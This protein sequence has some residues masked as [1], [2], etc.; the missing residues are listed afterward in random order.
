[1]D[2]SLLTAGQMYILNNLF[3]LLAYLVVFAFSSFTIGK[4]IKASQSILDV[5]LTGSI[6]N[7]AIIIIAAIPVGIFSHFLL[8]Y[9]DLTFILQLGLAAYGIYEI[10]IERRQILLRFPSAK[11]LL[12]KRPEIFIVLAAQPYV[13]L[14]T[15]LHPILYEWDYSVYYGTYLES[16]TATGSLPTTNIFHNLSIFETWFP[17]GASIFYSFIS[18]VFSQEF[19]RIIPYFVYLLFVVVAYKGAS[20]ISKKQDLSAWVLALTA[21]SPLVIT[22]LGTYSLYPDL[23]SALFVA[24]AMIYAYEAGYYGND[25]LIVVAALSTALALLTKDTAIF[26]FPMV[27]L[28][29]SYSSKKS[30]LWAISIALI[31]FTIAGYS[32]GD[33]FTGGNSALGYARLLASVPTTGII[34]LVWFFSRTF[35][36]PRGKI[37]SYFGLFAFSLLGTAW[38]M[39]NVIVLKSLFFPLII[40]ARYQSEYNIAYALYRS[41]PIVSIPITPIFSTTSQYLQLMLEYSN[42]VNLDLLTG[43]L[44]VF[45]F[46][47]IFFVVRR[48]SSET[49]FALLV[50]LLMTFFWQ[51]VFLFDQ[52]YGN[53]RHLLPFLPFFLTICVFGIDYLIEKIRL[54]ESL[55]P[56][57]FLGIL[58]P[59]ALTFLR[60]N[61]FDIGVPLKTGLSLSPASSYL[62]TSTIE[63]SLIS[64]CVV[65]VMTLTSRF[66]LRKK[67]NFSVTRSR[68]SALTKIVTLCL[69]VLLCSV[70]LFAI[71]P[72]QTSYGIA[73][74]YSTDPSYQFSL[75]YLGW[76]QDYTPIIQ[77]Y[78]SGA[79]PISAVTLA[80]YDVGIAYYTHHK[81]IDLRDDVYGYMSIYKLL[82]SNNSQEILSGLRTLNI[83]YFLIPNDQHI[84]Y[85]SFVSLESKTIFFD[86]IRDPKVSKMIRHF[87]TLTLYQL[88]PS[89]K[90]TIVE[91][92][93]PQTW[94]QL[95]LNNSSNW[96]VY[97]GTTI[98]GIDNVTRS[99]SFSFN[100]TQRCCN[101]LIRYTFSQPRDWSNYTGISFRWSGAKGTAMQL[102]IGSLIYNN[103]ELF[104]F[105]G[106]GTTTTYYFD[107]SDASYYVGQINMRSVRV[108]Q[109]ST[110]TLHVSGNATFSF[111]LLSYDIFN[112]TNTS[113]LGFLSL[114]GKSNPNGASDG[115]TNLF[116]NLLYSYSE[117]RNYPASFDTGLSGNLNLYSNVT[118]GD[119]FGSAGKMSYSVKTVVLLPNS[120][121]IFLYEKGTLIPG[122]DSVSQIYLGNLGPMTG[123]Y[124][125]AQ[126]QLDFTRGDKNYS[127]LLSL[128]TLGQASLPNLDF[129]NG[130]WYELLGGQQYEE[131][132]TM[133]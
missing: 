22:Y 128:Q 90:T 126:V 54:R 15:V 92:A 43:T 21:L 108:V 125:I 27:L 87:S 17:P 11:S 69:L 19:I 37:S 36:K 29:Y 26:I 96:H 99:I 46:I 71:Y 83:T 120:T 115:S 25:R 103:G 62:S 76:N 124:T 119:I 112:M 65:V 42:L 24:L 59:Y 32:Y 31:Y 95:N 80:W 79:V 131:T 75:M 58:L 68:V 133:S 35:Y 51:N 105:N 16:I 2:F 5:V 73:S 66:I 6:V 13:F 61:S 12:F 106:T 84:Q 77:Y 57:A 18:T 102:Y 86:L 39:R 98:S 129:S 10:V 4:R 97:N 48:H 130:Y 78:L 94:I 110:S 104:Y 3:V 70:T 72:T 33:I 93:P 81:V 118:F 60:I 123:Y 56:W 74:N 127:Y 47:G 44:L 89:L 67:M 85:P 117:A 1:M 64:L 55:R 114:I 121:T 109:I 8:E 7:F 34:C 122:M 82:F 63:Y 132:L 100:A 45:E 91:P 20:T 101:N 50:L 28:C 53:L 111:P 23:L 41:S 49:M 52:T 38:Y 40:G 107:F 30:I 116:P 113:Y 9:F 14:L 88:K